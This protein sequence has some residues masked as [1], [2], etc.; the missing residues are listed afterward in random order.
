M[1]RRWEDKI[2]VKDLLIKCLQTNP[3]EISKNY[4]GLSNY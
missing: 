1:L 2:W 3:Y 4:K